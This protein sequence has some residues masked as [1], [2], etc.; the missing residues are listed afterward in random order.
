MTVDLVTKYHV[1]VEYA[2]KQ[3]SHFWLPDEV[4][5]EKDVQSILVDMTDS[6]RHGVVT[7]LQLFTH[8]EL[9]AGEDYWLGRYM[10]MF[11]RHEFTRMASV[12]G[13]VELAI[14]KPFYSKINEVLGLATEEFYGNYVEDP[15]LAARMEMIDGIISDPDD[16]ISLAGFTFIEGAVLYSS[17]AFLKHFQVN[18]KNKLLNVVRG[19]NFSLRDENLHAEASAWS[20]REKARHADT[21]KVEEVIRMMAMKV[22]EH[23]AHIIDKIFSKGPI[24][25]LTKE[26]MKTFAKSRVDHCLNLLAMKPLFN[27][28]NNVVAEWFYDSSNKVQINDRFTGIG[29]SYHRDWSAYEFV[30][31][32]Y[33]PTS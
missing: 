5:V 2:T 10:K 15:V 17:F 7:T 19:I 20:Y 11:P 21:T 33:T 27:V 8:Y 3:L 12:F 9:K 30:Y 18:G 4:K 22:Y 31:Q 26:D 14:H 1:P 24:E 25:G 6:E 28:T 32:S 23:E 29:S 13:M 16:L